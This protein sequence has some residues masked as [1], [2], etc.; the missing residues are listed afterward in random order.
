[1]ADHQHQTLMLAMSISSSHS[2]EDEA[3]GFSMNV[4]FPASRLALASG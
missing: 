1:M 3:I 4:C 2:A